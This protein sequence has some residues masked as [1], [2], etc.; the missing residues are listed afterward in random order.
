MFYYEIAEWTGKEK[1]YTLYHW[2]FQTGGSIFGK[3]SSNP[4]PKIGED[5]HQHMEH[6]KMECINIPVYKLVA[7]YF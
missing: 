1:K 7:K 3:R 6:T 5:K 2:P 4:L